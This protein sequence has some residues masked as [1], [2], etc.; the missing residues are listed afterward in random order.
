MADDNVYER[1]VA[2]ADRIRRQT[3][4]VQL[5]AYC[6]GCDGVVVDELVGAAYQVLA[7]S[8]GLDCPPYVRITCPKCEAK[9]QFLLTW[10]HELVTARPAHITGVTLSDDDDN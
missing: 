2:L 9:V 4:I 10:A 7:D 1:W 5:N 3:A 8:M 6:P